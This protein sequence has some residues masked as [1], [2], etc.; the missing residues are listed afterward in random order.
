MLA[1]HLAEIKHQ[2]ESNLWYPEPLA[3]GKLSHNTLHWENLRTATAVTAAATGSKPA[4]ETFG[5]PNWQKKKNTTH[6]PITWR[7]H[8]RASAFMPIPGLDTGGVT[9]ELNED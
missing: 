7:D 5:R 8:L 1:P 9:T 3:H 6:K 2:P 4:W